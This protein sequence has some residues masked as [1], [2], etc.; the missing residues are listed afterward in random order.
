MPESSQYGNSSHLAAKHPLHQPVYL[1]SHKLPAPKQNA[2][3]RITELLSELGVNAQKLVMPTRSNI[4]ELD[5]LLQAAAGLVDMKR[6]VDRIGQELRT[7][8]A[9]REGHIVPIDSARK[10]RMTGQSHLCYS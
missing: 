9:Q 5:G 6:Q 8:Q 10:V 7:L 4:E 3:I 1:R 2:A